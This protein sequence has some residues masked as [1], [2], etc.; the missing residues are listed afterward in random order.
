[1]FKL[2][3]IFFKIG[4][5][6]LGGGYAMVPLIEEEIVEK[7]DWMSEDEFLDVLVMAQS[8]PGPLAVNTATFVGYR[9]KKTRGAAV[10]CLGTVLPSFLIILTIASLLT[11]FYQEPKVLSF[12]RGV[13]PAVAALIFTAVFKLK[14]GIDASLFSIV[15]VVFA[16]LCVAVMS[17]SP[18]IVIV[19]A[20]LSGIFIYPHTKWRV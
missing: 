19:V 6:T 16:I 20:A 1:M 3:K 4:M 5:F 17:W 14:K 11:N 13:R 8:L 10:C 9:L 2:F 7:N 12:F 18:I 15:M